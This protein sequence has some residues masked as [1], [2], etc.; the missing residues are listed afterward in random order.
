[1]TTREAALATARAVFDARRARQPAGP[2]PEALRP[3]DAASG[4][5][6]QLELARLWDSVPPAGFKLGATGARMRAYLGVAEP[7]AGFMRLADL[8]ASGVVLPFADFRR[9]GVECEIAVRLAADLPPGPCDPARAAAA[10]G[11]VMAAIEIVENRYDPPGGDLAAMGAPTLIADQMFHAAAVLG[12][13]QPPGAIDLAAITGEISLD[14]V[15]LDGGEG[16]ELLGH[17]MAAL[18]WL[19]G[20]REALAFGGLKSGQVVLLGSVTPPV[21]L[22]GPGTVRVQ[23]GDAGA[24]GLGEVVLTFS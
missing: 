8:H 22:A 11:R 23:F 9:V 13:E 10:V 5:A 4:V 2:L 3:A 15:R 16:R 19:A 17:P 14:G 6:A 1:M 18:A 20:S 24:P 12:A 21:W 7:I